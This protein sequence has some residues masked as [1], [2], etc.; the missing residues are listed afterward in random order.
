MGVRL[1]EVWREEDC[2]NVRSNWWL[3][4]CHDCEWTTSGGQSRVEDATEEHRETTPPVPMKPPLA[5]MVEAPGLLPLFRRVGVLKPGERAYVPE[6]PGCLTPDLNAMPSSTVWRSPDGRWK[7]EISSL[8]PE[9]C[10]TCGTTTGEHD[11]ATHDTMTVYRAER[12]ALKAA[13]VEEP[14]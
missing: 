9:P 5:G 13:E 3:G 12:E 8:A 2:E 14:S 4:G 1:H 11:G 7:V 10:G 6:K